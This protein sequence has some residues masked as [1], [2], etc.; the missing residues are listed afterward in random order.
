MNA[1]SRQKNDAITVDLVQL[2][3]E[4]VVALYESAPHAQARRSAPEG[5]L[6]GRQMKAI[7]FLAHRGRVTMGELADGLEIGRAAASELV[8]RLVEKEVVR[9]A[10]DPADRR[11]VTVTLSDSAESL[12]VDVF[13]QWSAQVAA[14]LARYPDLDPDTLIAFLQALI[15]KLK[16][17]PET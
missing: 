11:V 8:E 4:L 14:A 2:L 9:R 6:T 13:A 16:G 17:R 5:G 7:V 15:D 12:A 3:P 10:H 1:S